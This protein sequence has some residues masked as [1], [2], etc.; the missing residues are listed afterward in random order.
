M[1]SALAMADITHSLVGN[2]FVNTFIGISDVKGKNSLGLRPFIY[3]F[4]FVKI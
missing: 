4:F 3:T 2:I 1:F